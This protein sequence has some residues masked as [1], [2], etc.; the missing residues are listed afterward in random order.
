MNELS[1]QQR[2]FLK[3]LM[4]NLKCQ[5]DF[6]CLNN[7]FR[8]LCNAENIDLNAFIECLESTDLACSFQ[9]KVVKS[10]YCDCP[11]RVYISK[12][13][14]EFFDLLNKPDRR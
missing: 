14:S 6:K 11:I 4:E 1:S 5:K 8:D 7:S 12:H 10:S 3:S 13:E 9:L 2:E